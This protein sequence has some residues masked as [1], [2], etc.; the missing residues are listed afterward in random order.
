LTSTPKPTEIPDVH[1]N[2]SKASDEIIIDEKTNQFYDPKTKTVFYLNEFGYVTTQST[3]SEEE[4]E[5]RWNE[6]KNTLINENPDLVKEKDHSN[7]ISSPDE[8]PSLDEMISEKS[9]THDVQT[10]I[11]KRDSEN[12]N[13]NDISLN[14]YLNTNTQ[15]A[16]PDKKEDI[17]KTPE[18]EH[19]ADKKERKEENKGLDVQNSLK[20]AAN[21][22][23][24]SLNKNLKGSDKY[25]DDW[26]ISPDGNFVYSMRYP[27]DDPIPVQYFEKNPD[28]NNW[29]R[30]WVQIESAYPIF[31][32]P[33]PEGEHLRVAQK[34]Y[35]TITKDPEV[36]KKLDSWKDEP[37]V[38]KEKKEFANIIANAIIEALKFD[39]EYL[40]EVRFADEEELNPGEEAAFIDSD[41]TILIRPDSEIW[42][43]PAVLIGTV[44]HEVRHL[45]QL[46]ASDTLPAGEFREG[47]QQNWDSQGFRANINEHGHNYYY[48][49]I[50]EC[51][52]F[53]VCE[54]VIRAFSK[55]G[56]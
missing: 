44:A 26:S 48:M 31:G 17:E 16:E 19:N 39:K 43:D 22:V 6:I 24:S 47:I 8:N 49:Q 40:N 32:T 2:E 45:Q 38:L 20:N 5:R 35:D 51:D 7:T 55:K 9:Q 10:D 14:Y 52:A 28:K 33:I 3:Y 30:N 53:G 13:N 34:I 21:A 1:V 36:Q 46:C 23:I 11:E 50:S 27:D 12:L 15:S 18:I 25:P 54:E 4:L 29:D 42:K 41:K 56:L 37:R